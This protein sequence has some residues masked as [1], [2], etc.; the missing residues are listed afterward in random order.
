[1]LSCPEIICYQLIY[2]ESLRFNPRDIWD[3][4]VHAHVWIS[5][6]ILIGEKMK[7]DTGSLLQCLWLAAKGKG[8]IHFL[9]TFSKVLSWAV[10][11][12]TGYY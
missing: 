6:A 5:Q 1:M 12:K 4:L 11:Q 2:Y 9:Q 7:C 8:W 10:A 3:G